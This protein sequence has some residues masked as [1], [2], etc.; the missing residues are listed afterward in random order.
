MNQRVR[1]KTDASYDKN[2]GIG[3][4]YV[5]EI[6]GKKFN[7]RGYVNKKCTSTKAEMLSTAWSIHHATKRIDIDPSEYSL[8]VGTDC[9]ST[10]N[11]YDDGYECKNMRFINH[12]SDVYDKMMMFWIP[13]ETNQKAD[14][15]AKLMLRKAKDD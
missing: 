10:V 8:V 14:Q 15:I 12:Y 1:I 5:C 6:N 4:G 7:G 13:R 3:M 11:K 9:E 2:V